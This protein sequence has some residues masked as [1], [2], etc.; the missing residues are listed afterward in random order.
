MHCYYHPEKEGVVQCANCGITLCRECEENSHFRAGNGKGQ[1][2]CLR[3]S[4]QAAQ[5]IVDY[6]TAWLK[7][8]KKKLSICT[9]LIV[10]GVLLWSGHSFILFCIAGIIFSI[11]NPPPQQTQKE[12]MVDAIMIAKNPGSAFIG[13]LLGYTFA[14]PFVLFAS[15]K[16]YRQTAE[17]LKTDIAN[18]EAVKAAVQAQK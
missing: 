3:C 7:N 9:P 14:A 6:K 10:L 16:S 13:T 5:E 1:A 8:R 11:G 18:L 12:A 17:E 15:I 2:L 4:L